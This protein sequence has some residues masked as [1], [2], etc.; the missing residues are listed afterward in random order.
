MFSGVHELQVS[1]DN[2]RQ[3]TCAPYRM[4]TKSRAMSDRARSYGLQG[5]G[6][7]PLLFV[8]KNHAKFGVPY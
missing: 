6:R 2:I 7:S 8:P 3:L 4:P 1:D 5:F